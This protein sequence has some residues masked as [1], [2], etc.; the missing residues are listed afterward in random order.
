MNTRPQRGISG[1]NKQGHGEDTGPRCS[2][3]LWF[4]AAPI[5]G[6]L[7]VTGFL[8]L[9]R[10]LGLLFV[11]GEWTAQ[12]VGLVFDLLGLTAGDGQLWIVNLIL[13]FPISWLLVLVA[14]AL[15]SA[16]IAAAERLEEGS[17]NKRDLQKIR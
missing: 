9:A 14:P 5:A 16:I 6:A 11:T 4:A 15:F 17:A 13:G 10:E 7:G 3:Y 8:L 1:R 12:P 2:D